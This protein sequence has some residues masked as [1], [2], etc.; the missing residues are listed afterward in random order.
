MEIPGVQV[1]RDRL[2]LPV[3]LDGAAGWAI[4]DTGAQLSVVGLTMAGRLGLNEQTMAD[5][6]L[7]RQHGV[8][9]AMRMAHVHRFG[10][11]RIGPTETRNPVMA[12][13][14]QEAGLADML[15]G[16]D[17]LRG[18]RVWLSFRPAQ[19]FVTLR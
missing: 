9:P 16:E 19:V 11:L 6:P 1:R 3:T 12:V 14:P 7:I 5:D 2:L 10:V 13:L 18:R 4:L 8:G 15:I 17:F